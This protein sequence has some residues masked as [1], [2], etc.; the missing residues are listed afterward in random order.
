MLRRLH[1][2]NTTLRSPEARVDYTRVARAALRR[3]RA[4]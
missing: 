1:G 4:R 3:R 2:A